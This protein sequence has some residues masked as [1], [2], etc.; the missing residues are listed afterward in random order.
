MGDDWP[1]LPL[2]RAPALAC[3]PPNAHAEAR[4]WPTTSP[5]RRRARRGARILRP[6]AD[7]RPA[8]TPAPAHGHLSTLDG[9]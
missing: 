2:L 8:A 9:R 5:P 4:P 6:A 7:G 1:D 3:A